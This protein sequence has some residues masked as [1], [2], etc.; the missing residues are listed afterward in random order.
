MKNFKYKLLIT[1]FVF[2]FLVA[3]TDDFVR[4]NPNNVDTENYFN[5][6]EEYESARWSL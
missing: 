4:V 2:S 1:F 3:C 5:S 6:E